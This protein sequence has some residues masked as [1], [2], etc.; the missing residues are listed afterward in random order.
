MKEGARSINYHVSIQFFI[1]N[2]TVLG[3]IL[4]LCPFVLYSPMTE[5]LH[6]F[7]QKIYEEKK[8]VE[9][10]KSIPSSPRMETGAKYEGYLTK[11]G[12][13]RRNWKQVFE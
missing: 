6:Q 2:K 9:N 5:I 13:F 8:E 1:F 3:S 10:F 7:L 11:K 12:A 4:S